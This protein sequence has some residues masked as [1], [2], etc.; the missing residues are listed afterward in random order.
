MK[1]Y[2]H[3][4]SMQTEIF[5][6]WN[7]REFSSLSTD[8]SHSFSLEVH[9]LTLSGC[10]DWLFEQFLEVVSWLHQYESAW[11]CGKPLENK[12]PTASQCSRNRP[13]SLQKTAHAYP[14]IAKE[15]ECEQENATPWSLDSHSCNAVE[16]NLARRSYLDSAWRA[17]ACEWAILSISCA[18][19]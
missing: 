6:E 10:L 17:C 19:Q 3:H 5:E 7:L 15:L 16:Q 8:K 11:D 13:I 18:S 9:E 12:S 4:M 14:G 2:I 1:K